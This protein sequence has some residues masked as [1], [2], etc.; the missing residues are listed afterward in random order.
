MVDTCPMGPDEF[1]ANPTASA[2]GAHGDIIK[3]EDSEE[4]SGLKTSLSNK[5]RQE[6][7]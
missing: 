4:D 7:L 3:L 2:A 6:V 5:S 1:S